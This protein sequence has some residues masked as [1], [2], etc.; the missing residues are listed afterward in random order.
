[1]VSPSQGYNGSVLNTFPLTPVPNFQARVAANSGSYEALSCQNTVLADIGTR[2]LSSASLLVTPNG[3]TEGV[4]FSTLPNSSSGDFTVTRATTAT[5]VN[6]DGLVELVPYNLVS[7]SEDF[8][9]VYW[10]K[11]FSTVLSNTVNSPINTLTADTLLAVT[12]GGTQYSQLY[13]FLNVNSGTTYSISVYAKKNSSN[14]VFFREYFST[15]TQNITWFNLLTG[16]IGTTNPNHIATIVDVGGGWYRCIITTTTNA[17]RNQSFGIGVSDLDNSY[18][19][20]ATSSIFIWGAQLV[21]G[22]NALPYQPTTTR[23]NI[24]RADYSLGGC[25]NILLEPQRTNLVLASEQFDSGSWNK[26]AST[27]TPNTAI[28]PS[29]LVNADTLIGDGLFAQHQLLGIAAV[30]S[31]STYTFTIYAKKNTNNFI[32]LFT[33][34]AAGGMFANFDLNNGVVG[35]LGT[36]TGSN[37]TSSITNVGNGWYRCSMTF[38]P[39]SSVSSATNSLT[40][41][42]SANASRV[43]A[44]SLS[45]S[46]FLWGAQ[47]EAGA[48]ATSYIPTTSATVT[49]NQDVISAIIPSIL[50][51]SSGTLFI[52]AFPVVT[53]AINQTIATINDGT[54]SRGFWLG[55]DNGVLQVRFRN[56]GGVQAANSSFSITNLQRIKIALTWNG[57][58]ITLFANG[59]KRFNNIVLGADYPSTINTIQM[60]GD[61][62]FF[63]INRNFINSMGL[64]PVPLSDSQCIELTTL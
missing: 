34:N 55:L 41:T 14:F 44:N 47:L 30:V 59:V 37:P 36:T 19:I 25:P 45:T 13:E 33:T 12:G 52:D 53:S 50:N 35:T 46:V 28:S 27:I 2:I 7:Y 6:S 48:Y 24:S 31:G 11:Q 4:L 39:N 62:S 23:L 40:L 58:A 10:D 5:R 60:Q 49:R 56:A 51:A 57:S 8:T 38:T 16:Q 43:E 9:N 61:G 17:A 21:E 42:T 22:T 3:Y 32:Q 29:G 18:I 15:G 63:G 54:T 20:T 64:A 1:V 26:L